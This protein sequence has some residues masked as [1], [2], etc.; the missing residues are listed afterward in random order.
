MVTSIRF[1][2]WVDLYFITAELINFVFISSSN[3][4]IIFRTMS[5]YVIPLDINPENY[6]FKLLSCVKQTIPPLF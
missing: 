2:V 5:P 3:N 1:Q 4:S 6:Y